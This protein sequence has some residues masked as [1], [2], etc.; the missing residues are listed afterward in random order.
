MAPTCNLTFDLIF[1]FQTSFFFLRLSVCS[2]SFCSRFVFCVR[3]SIP[4]TNKSKGKSQ[5]E[6]KTKENEFCVD[7]EKKHE[8]D[9]NVLKNHKAKNRIEKVTMSTHSEIE[10]T[11]L[12]HPNA[13]ECQASIFYYTSSVTDYHIYFSK[14]YC[15]NCVRMWF[16]FDATERIEKVHSPRNGKY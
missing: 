12:F 8:K 2:T 6:R 1:V 14:R 13:C 4:K 15:N 7:G 16:I 11:L 10:N 5:D 3:F 9:K